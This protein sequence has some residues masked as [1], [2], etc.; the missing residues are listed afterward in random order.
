MYRSGMEAQRR[1]QPRKRET[2]SHDGG[3]MRRTSVYGKLQVIAGHL[4]ARAYSVRPERFDLRQFSSRASTGS[5]KE[6]HSPLPPR[7][8]P[9]NCALYGYSDRGEGIA[10]RIATICIRFARTALANFD[11]T[12]LAKFSC[13]YSPILFLSPRPDIRVDEQSPTIFGAK[14]RCSIASCNDS[15]GG[16]ISRVYRRHGETS[17]RPCPSTLPFF[18]DIIPSLVCS[19]YAH[20]ITRHVTLTRPKTSKA[21]V[22]NIHPTAFARSL[23]H[24][25]SSTP[26]FHDGR[27]GGSRVRVLNNRRIARD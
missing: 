2:A 26:S 7:S 27:G 5:G 16:Y 21:K 9:R 22:V 11:I 25:G 20:E 14:L 6:G 17:L 3:R 24:D 15:V 4:F 23:A 8:L 12:E 18:F 19:P 10:I 1:K 13:A